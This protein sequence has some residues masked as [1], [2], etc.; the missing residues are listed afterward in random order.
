VIVGERSQDVLVYFYRYGFV[1]EIMT[2]YKVCIILAEPNATL[3]GFLAVIAASYLTH[4]VKTVGLQLTT[5]I[6]CLSRYLD[7]HSTRFAMLN[8]FY[9]MQ[10]EIEVFAASQIAKEIT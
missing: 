5:A 3:S 6:N 8:D 2:K 9:F 7:R 10:L 4:K 1:K